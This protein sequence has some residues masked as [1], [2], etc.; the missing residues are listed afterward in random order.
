MERPGVIGLPVAGCELKLVPAAGKLEVR[1][2]GPHVTPGYYKR[3]DLTQAAF[4]EEGFYR[5][6]DAGIGKVVGD[7]AWGGNWFFLVEQHG[8]KLDLANVEQLTDYT[9]RVRQAI[10]KEFP[11]IDHIEL[12]GTPTRADADSRNF[13]LCPGAAYDRSPCGTGTSAD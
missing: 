5:I 13:V 10:N 9:W 12:F 11:E 3:P 1:V 6:G 4:D 8:Q 2:R 7:V